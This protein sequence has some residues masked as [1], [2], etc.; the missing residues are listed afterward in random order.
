MEKSAAL[1]GVRL[2]WKAAT[3]GISRGRESE[4]SWPG[5]RPRSG[6]L[7]RG[8]PQ[9]TG[10]A[11]RR[12]ALRQAPQQSPELPPFIRALT[13]EMN[14]GTSCPLSIH[15][16]RN[17]P[18]RSPPDRP[19]PRRGGKQSR[20]VLEPRSRF[21]WRTSRSASQSLSIRF[22]YRPAG[23]RRHAQ[24]AFLVTKGE[25]RRAAFSWR[26]PEPG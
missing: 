20:G 3:C 18:P 9:T 1:F 8:G 24:A 11:R 15:P 2:E 12:P 5:T 13:V 22:R 23:E 19:E 21:A 6:S 25:I 16:R 10:A 17:A 14:P 4:L 7:R 26:H